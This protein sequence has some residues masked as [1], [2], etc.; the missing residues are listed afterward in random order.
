MIINDKENDDHDIVTVYN[1]LEQNLDTKIAK[2]AS[3]HITL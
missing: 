2:I 1:Y 3:T